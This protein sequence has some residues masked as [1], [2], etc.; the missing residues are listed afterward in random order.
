[1]TILRAMSPA[2]IVAVAVQ[3]GCQAFKVIFYSLRRRSFQWRF[4]FSAGGM[5]SSHSAFVT[6][7]AV[8]V[9]LGSGFAT[10]L[11]ALA[12]VFAAI[13]IY[14]AIRLRGAVQKQSEALAL[15]AELL[16]E[17][18][19]PSIP[20]WVGHSVTEIVAGVLVGAGLAY[21]AFLLFFR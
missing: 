15:L 13:V 6:A 18:R 3:L 8:S 19:R 17:E 16:P 20:M 21:L 1:M 4:F 5:P 10:D 12:F 9:G 2:L 14:D 11:F 7:L